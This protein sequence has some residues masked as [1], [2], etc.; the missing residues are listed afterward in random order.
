MMRMTQKN[1]IVASYSRVLVDFIQKCKNQETTIQD[2]EN[3]VS[4]LKDVT[5]SEVSPLNYSSY[6]GSMLEIKKYLNDSSIDNNE[7]INFLFVVL[8]RKYGFLLHDIVK[9]A[10]YELQNKKGVTE[11]DVYS[12]APLNDKMKN[13]VTKM[14]EN[15]ISN[16]VISFQ[17]N[18][19][20]SRNSI[21]FVSNGKISVLNLQQITKKIL[22]E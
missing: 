21:E 11:V 16:V 6:K 14:I 10:K 18:P 7:I 19:N 22:S 5:N 1:R 20:V 15:Q 9:V 3:A 12:C 17:I 13:E 4:L 2:I 8:Q